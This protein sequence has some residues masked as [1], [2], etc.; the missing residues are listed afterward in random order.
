MHKRVGRARGLRLQVPSLRL[1]ISASP[2]AQVEHTY[3]VLSVDRSPDDHP[4][5]PREYAVSGQQ[6]AG[7]TKR[8]LSAR[9]DVR[10]VVRVPSS[11]VRP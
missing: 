4:F 8:T 9:S 5:I 11:L 6:Y 7:L 1:R 3:K 2:W 10:S